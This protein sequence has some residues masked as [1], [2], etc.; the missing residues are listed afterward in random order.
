MLIDSGTDCKDYSALDVLLIVDTSTVS[1]SVFAEYT[2][3]VSTYVAEQFPA[4]GARLAVLTFSTWADVVVNL[5]T[6]T[7]LTTVSTVLL[8]LELTPGVPFTSH[9]LQDGYLLFVIFSF[10]V[11]VLNSSP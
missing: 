10:L 1:A 5:T 4:D 7:S 3:K 6:G 11:N 8:D 2:A 9:A